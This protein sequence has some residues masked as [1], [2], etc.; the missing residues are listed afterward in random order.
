MLASNYKCLQCSDILMG[1]GVAG[2]DED[3]D[4]GKEL[5]T[6]GQAKACAEAASQA[7][8]KF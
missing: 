1:K 3:V 4:R 5:R 8:V 7:L 2:R 6:Q